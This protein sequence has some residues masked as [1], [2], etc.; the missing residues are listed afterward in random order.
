MRRGRRAWGLRIRLDGLVARRFPCRRTPPPVNA[1]VDALI[2]GCGVVGT[3]VG[4]L[5][6]ARGERVLGVRRS[7]ATAVFPLSVG[8]IA[9][10]TTWDGLAAS[11]PRWPVD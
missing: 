4:E 2:L 5:L 6:E 10:P 8:D 11:A 1:P 9:D 7:A 3:L